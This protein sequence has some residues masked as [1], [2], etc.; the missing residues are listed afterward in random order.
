MVDD[1]RA[2]GFNDGFRRHPAR[3]VS[4]SHEAQTA[5]LDAYREGR[6]HRAQVDEVCAKEQCDVGTLMKKA[7]EFYRDAKYGRPQ[8]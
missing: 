2:A 1:A 7:F 6:E 8:T 3:A 5:Y 4:P